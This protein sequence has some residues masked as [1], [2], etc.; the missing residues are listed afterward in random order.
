MI[1]AWLSEIVLG[2]LVIGFLAYMFK[3]FIKVPNFEYTV[4]IIN[5]TAV[6]AVA[7]PLLGI[8]VHADSVVMFME[9]R[10]QIIAGG[11]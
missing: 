1:T 7:L 3:G 6:W 9:L 2:L 11:Y 10:N 5:W 8:A 4:G